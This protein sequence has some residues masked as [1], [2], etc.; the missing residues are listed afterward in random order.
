MEATSEYGKVYIQ[1]EKN[2]GIMN[3]IWAKMDTKLIRQ[4][5]HPLS[6]GHHQRTSVTGRYLWEWEIILGNS[7]HKLLQRIAILTKKPLASFQHD[8]G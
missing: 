6:I 1:T 2:H 8:V 7:L 4:I 3:S 5:F